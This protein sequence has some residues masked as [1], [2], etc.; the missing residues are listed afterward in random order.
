MTNLLHG[1]KQ[2]IA[3][4]TR[5]PLDRIE[6][7]AAAGVLEPWDSIAHVHI[8]LAIEAAIGRELTPEEIVDCMDVRSIASVLGATAD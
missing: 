3:E 6:D 5:E 4:A 1:A 8:M 2:I 7:D